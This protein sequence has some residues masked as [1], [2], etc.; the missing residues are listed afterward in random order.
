MSK[1]KIYDKIYWYCLGIEEKTN[2]IIDRVEKIE[3]ENSELGHNCYKV[4]Y[5]SKGK[6]G[7][8]I[9]WIGKKGTGIE[10]NG[11]RRYIV[12]DSGELDIIGINTYLYNRRIK[13]VLENI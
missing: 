10:L 9:M 6:P 12:D 13:E 5:N 7:E 4:Y 1:K 11:T 2:V 3:T 8:F